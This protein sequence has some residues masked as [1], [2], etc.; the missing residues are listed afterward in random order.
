MSTLAHRFKFY[1]FGF[2]IGCVVVW[3]MFYNGR[4]KRPAWLP[5]GRVI[6]FLQKSE[7]TINKNLACKLECNNIPLDF[8][9]KDFWKNADI[10]FDKSAT[11]RIPCPEYVISS[12]TKNGKAIV[13]Y[14][15]SC[16][17]CDNCDRQGKATLRSFEIQKKSTC[18]CD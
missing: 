5:E 6:E 13:V 9:D 15:E 10:D 17:N 4:D 14:I 1:L 18:K 7:I 12:K 3:A 16:E 8:M 2:A 11:K